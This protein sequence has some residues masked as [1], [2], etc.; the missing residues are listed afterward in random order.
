MSLLHESFA[1][2]AMV[3]E[4]SNIGRIARYK[5]LKD[6]HDLHRSDVLDGSGPYFVPSVDPVLFGHF[7]D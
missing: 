4:Q 6:L 3:P 2:S 1:S 5:A 7:P